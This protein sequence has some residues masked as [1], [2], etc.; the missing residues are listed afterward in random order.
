[1]KGINDLCGISADVLV[2]VCACLVMCMYILL[3]VTERTE[4]VMYVSAFPTDAEISLPK[5]QQM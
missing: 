5:P 1:M 2:S 4:I 3:V